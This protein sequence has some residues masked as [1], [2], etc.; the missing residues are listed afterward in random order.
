MS[1]YKT[2]T[3]AQAGLLSLAVLALLT[4]V[5]FAQAAKVKLHGMIKSRSGPTMTVQPADSQDG[6]V[7]LLT[8]TQV[9]Q[10]K[11]VLKARHK[12]MSMAA[13]IPGLEI[14]VEG[15]YNGLNQV[16]ASSVKFKGNDLERAQSI[17]A[18]LHQTEAQTQRNKEEL[19]KQKAELRAE[20]QKVAANREAISAN[21][22]K[23]A[24]NRA[25]IQAAIT[26]F[27]QL[28][29]YYI[30]DEVVVLFGNGKVAVESQYKPQ[31]L[32]LAKKAKTIDAY[33]VQVVGYASA[34]GS[35]AV[36]QKL[37]EDRASSVTR[38][39]DAGRR[40]SAHQFTC[41]RRDGR[42]PAG[43]RQQVG[44]RSG[45]KPPRRGEN[46]AKQGNRGTGVDALNHP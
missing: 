42:E 8:A 32:A 10:I 23:I 35:A 6:V 1:R 9:G 25:T 30:L 34:V 12:D 20:Q 41:A 7:V 27:G 45:A 39:T 24:S 43:G 2:A 17:Q 3:A 15:N 44:G 40:R 38:I 16:V 26:R 22:A 37:S 13:L 19:E 21:E 29:D 18:G 36:N 14:Q 33:M 11:G 4:T 31:L 5:S 46:P 28:D